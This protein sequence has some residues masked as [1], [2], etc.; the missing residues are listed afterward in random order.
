M[1]RKL[2]ALWI[3]AFESCIE[4][5]VAQLHPVGADPPALRQGSRN[6]RRRVAVQDACES[7]GVALDFKGVQL[8]PIRGSTRIRNSAKRNEACMHRRG[9]L[10]R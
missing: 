9:P 10:P 4:D 2:R 5:D 1:P 7:S 3:A 6:L 8:T